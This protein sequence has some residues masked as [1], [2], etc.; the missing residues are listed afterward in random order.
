MTHCFAASIEELRDLDYVAWEIH[1]MSHENAMIRLGMGYPSPE[2]DIA[3]KIRYGE[4][5]SSDLKEL[6]EDR[7]GSETVK[8]FLQPVMCLVEVSVFLLIYV[9]N[10]SYTNINR[11]KNKW[12]IVF[13]VGNCLKYIYF[14]R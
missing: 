5:G 11:K 4:Q 10:K 6:I 9:K 1:S 14:R 12:V 2:S 8:H 7:K 3:F 13:V